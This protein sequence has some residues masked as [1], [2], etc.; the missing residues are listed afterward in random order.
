MYDTKK[1]KLVASDSFEFNNRNYTYAK[2]IVEIKKLMIRLIEEYDIAAVFIE[3]VQMQANRQAFKKLSWLQGVLI[4]YCEEN[5]ILY[6]LVAPRKWQGCCKLTGEPSERIKM[7]ESVGVK[8]SKLISIRFVEEQFG[9]ETN[10]DNLA[11]AICIGW[12][13]MN[14]RVIING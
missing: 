14:E 9:I 6:D 13:A 8:S 7:M 4:N 11:D 5:D 10:D 12:C 2:A 3:D 1:K